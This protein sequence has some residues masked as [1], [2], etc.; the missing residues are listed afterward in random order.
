[1]HCLSENDRTSAMFLPLIKRTDPEERTKT[2]V[3]RSG[4]LPSGCVRVRQGEAEGDTKMQSMNEMVMVLVYST[5][6]YH[7]NGED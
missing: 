6:T 3:L 2:C 4:K 7:W 5:K 1:M